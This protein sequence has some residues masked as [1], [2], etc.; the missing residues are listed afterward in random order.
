MLPALTYHELKALEP[1]KDDFAR[2]TKLMGGAKKWGG[3]KISAARARKAG[4]SFNDIVWAASVMAKKNKDVERR[5]RLWLADCAARVLHIYEANTKADYRPRDAIIASRAFARGETS[6]AARSATWEAAWDAAR[7]AA[8]SAA[9][10]AARSAAW[11][12][13]WAAAWDAARSATWEAARSATWE[14]AWDAARSAA[15]AAA[16]DAA[17]SAAWD[18]A[19]RSKVRRR[20]LAIRPPNRMAQRQRAE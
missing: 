18:A 8:R 11:A 16:W 3:K 9:R 15:W 2:V 20:V 1:C 14:A 19:G 4:A 12:A 6:T 7:S 17:R 13:A 5:I 10:D